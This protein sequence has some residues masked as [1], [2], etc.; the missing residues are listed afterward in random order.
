VSVSSVFCDIRS[1]GVSVSGVV[2]DSWSVGVSVSV[3]VCDSRIVS[4][5]VSSVVCDIHS[6]GVS[7]SGVVGG[8]RSV[9]V[10]VSGVVCGSWIV[11]GAVRSVIIRR[12]LREFV[13]GVTVG[14]DEAPVN[15]EVTCAGGGRSRFV[16]MEQCFD[17][18]IKGDLGGPFRA[19]WLASFLGDI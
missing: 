10:S 1:V 19:G 6:I 5:S 9:G 2:C 14:G 18:I 15:A 12:A 4:W 3:V 16:P 7:I 13:A 17:K 8:S 11:G